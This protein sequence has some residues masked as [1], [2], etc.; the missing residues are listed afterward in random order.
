MIDPCP[1]I[2]FITDPDLF[3]FNF[4]R[5]RLK[6]PNKGCQLYI[7]EFDQDNFLIFIL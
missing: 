2:L 7:N 3:L 5:E 1:S 6:T 4:D